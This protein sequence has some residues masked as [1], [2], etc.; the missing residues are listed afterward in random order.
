LLR[1]ATGE[2]VVVDERGLGSSICLQDMSNKD[3]LPPVLAQARR[4]IE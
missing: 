4:I 2:G 3:C 1:F